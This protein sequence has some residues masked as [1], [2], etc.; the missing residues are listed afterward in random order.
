MGKYETQET[1]AIV[2]IIEISNNDSRAIMLHRKSKG[3]TKDTKFLSIINVY[4]NKISPENNKNNEYKH[5]RNNTNI[6]II[7]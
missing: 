1:I 7:T 4:R 3:L 2:S 6:N 5:K